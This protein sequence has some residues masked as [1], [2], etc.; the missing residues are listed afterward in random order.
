MPFVSFEME[1]PTHY[2]IAFDRSIPRC[3]RYYES[4]EILKILDKILL[5]NNFDY[6]KDYISIVGYTL[7]L[8]IGIW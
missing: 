5:E 3:H 6:A 8:Y 4:S 7:E 2:I 1:L